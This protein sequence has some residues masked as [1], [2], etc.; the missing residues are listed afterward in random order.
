GRRAVLSLP[1]CCVMALALLATVECDLPAAMTLGW[2][3]DGFA[4][5]CPP[6]SFARGGVTI[7]PWSRPF[8][9]AASTGHAATRRSSADRARR[10]GRPVG[11]HKRSHVLA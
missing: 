5:Y 8:G 3:K 4:T 2:R 11:S 10:R 1:V 6:H 7:G 9:W